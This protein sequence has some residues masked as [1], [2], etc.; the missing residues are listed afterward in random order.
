MTPYNLLM[1]QK[2]RVFFALLIT[3]LFVPLAL[4]TSINAA[5]ASLKFQP[6]SMNLGVGERLIVDIIIDTAENEVA[7]CGAK[8]EYDPNIISVV[9]IDLGSIFNDYPSATFDNNTGRAMISGIVNS[10]K[11]LYKGQGKFGTITLQMVSTGMTKVKFEFT[12]GSTTDSNIAVTYGNGDILESVNELNITVTEGGEESTT[13][14]SYPMT[15]ASASRVIQKESTS[16]LDKLLGLVGI[17]RTSGYEMDPYEPFPSQAPNTDPS[18]SQ[19]EYRIERS[20]NTVYIIAAVVIIIFIAV[21]IMIKIKKRKKSNPP[22]IE[23]N[24]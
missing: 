22:V 16:T 17:K 15:S 6:S 3:L 12:P 19:P 7:G 2:A 24:I 11:N 1:L 4:P 23:Q 13:N 20:D 5:V 21:V 18:S 10:P 8:I 9:S 14:Q